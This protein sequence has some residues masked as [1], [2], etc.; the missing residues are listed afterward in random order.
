MHINLFIKSA[1]PR[2]FGKKRVLSSLFPAL[3]CLCPTFLWMTG[4]APSPQIQSKPAVDIYIT[5][6]EKDDSV[7]Q[8]GADL[9]AGESAQLNL[10][11][12]YWFGKAEESFVTAQKAAERDIQSAGVQAAIEDSRANLR[13][14]ELV[15][16]TSRTVLADAL[17]A[18]EAART[19]GA[20]GDEK[21]YAD[22]ENAL[23]D[24]SRAIEQ[25]KLSRAEKGRKKLIEKYR[26]LEIRALKKNAVDTAR[27]RLAQAKSA[28]ARSLVPG[29]YKEMEQAIVAADAFISANPSA[30]DNI[31][32]LSESLM[33][34]ADRLIF[35]TDAGNQFSSMSPGKIA[36]SWENY[37]HTLAGSLDVPDMRDQP[38]ETQME[39]LTAAAAA[40]KS[41]QA[42]LAQQNETLADRQA[43]I[44][45][46][47]MQLAMLEGK[48]RE[49]QMDL[50]RLTKAR[51]ETE[52]Q[53][54]AEKVYSR[55]Q[56]LVRATFKSNEAELYR[57]QDGRIVL[58]L[59]AMRFPVGK[60]TILPAHYAFLGKL[61]K[62]IR[63]INLS[64]VI[65]EGH[66]DATGSAEVNLRLS[67]QRAEA[68]QNYLIKN[69]TLPT[70]RIS[71]AGYG[72]ERPIATNDTAAGRAQNRRIDIVM[73][74]Q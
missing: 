57:Q 31:Q 58:R 6:T 21:T 53:V 54:E 30:R 62:V 43:K 59:K 68:V 10:L 23:L 34:Q 3:I 72:S 63:S 46:L 13:R 60:S 33:F 36:L 26:E 24:L 70:T 19:A 12:P 45:A 37:L 56:K 65:V 11:S 9:L 42:V 48:S 4:C 35:L 27:K 17:K 51:Q 28:G 41:D 29:P 40:L 47:N 7:S 16:T 15:A 50:E 20:A 69:R 44:D 38:F 55:L 39:T 1:F 52:Q 74:L 25:D 64:A 14:A 49:G 61:Q 22:A 5:P 2:M 71:A 8:L 18:R 66:T 32:A 67:Q 73:V